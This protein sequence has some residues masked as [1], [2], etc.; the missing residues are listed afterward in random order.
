MLRMIYGAAGAGQHDMMLRE[1]K[2]RTAQKKYSYIL[3]PEQFS[4]SAE[5][6]ILSVLGMSAQ[7]HVEVISFSRLSNM[8]LGEL[9]PLRMKYIDGAGRRI[10]ISRALNET[11]A[12]LGYL[13]RNVHQRGFPAVMEGV[14]SEFKRYGVTPA[15]ALETSK[16][17]KDEEL[18]CKLKDIAAVY[19]KYE[20][21]ISEKYSDAEDNLSL[22][23]PKIEDF[24]LN[25]GMLYIEEF[26]SFTPVEY[27]VLGS[28][29]QKID[30][31]LILCTESLK[32][33]PAAFKSAVSTWDKL[34]NIAQGAGIEISVP[35]K[36][37]SEVKF[38]ERPALAHLK[39]ELFKAR[40]IKYKNQTSEINIYA[41]KNYYAEVDAA[42]R[43]ISQLCHEKGYRFRDFLILARN[44]EKYA[45]IIPLVFESRGINVYLDKRRGIDKKPLMRAIF[46][47]IE[48]AAH[49]FSYDRVMS[50]ARSGFSKVSMRDIDIFENYLL[51][52]APSPRMWHTT[53]DWLF[54]PNK[55]VFDMD[56]INQIRIRL[57]GDTMNMLEPLRRSRTVAQIC[58][59]IKSW[60]KTCNIAG[61]VEAKY[62]LY[63]KRGMP[64]LAEELRQTWNALISILTQL[65][66]TM[67]SC[68]M[69]ASEFLDLFSAAASGAPVGVSPQTLDEVTFAGADRFRD[70]SAKVVIIFDMTEGVFPRAGNIEGIISDAE[71]EE[72]MRA[73]ME[74][75]PGASSRP[76]EEQNLIYRALTAAADSLYLFCPAEDSE[77]KALSPSPIA[78]KI[79]K[80]LFA[81]MDVYVPPYCETV[82]LMMNPEA[83]SES[84]SLEMVE[85]LY[86][87]ELMLSASKIERYNACAFSYFARYGLL[88]RPRDISNLE[89]KDMGSVLHDVLCKYFKQLA[90]DGGDYSAI[91]RNSCFGKIAE[92]TDECARSYDEMLYESS[93]YY[94]YMIM[95]MRRIAQTTAW[96]IVRFY[97]NSD[98]RPLG[99]EMRIGEG[100]DI[101][102]INIECASGNIKIVGAIDRADYAEINGKK[103][104]SILDYKSYKRKIED[105]EV[106][107]GVQIQPLLYSGA[108]TAKD[109]S[110]PA[111]MLYMQMSDP[112]IETNCNE[113]DE[114]DSK[115]HKELRPAGWVMDDPDVISAFDKTFSRT[116]G[117]FVP[118]K[119]GRLPREEMYERILNAEKKIKKSAE[120]ILSGDVSIKP[121]VSKGFSGCTYCDY[122]HIC[123]KKAK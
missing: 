34:C 86:G 115:K 56:E 24:S 12:E 107:G 23:A 54:N 49:G 97:K 80:E 119:G 9:G 89:P 31:C 102:P 71:R 2:T 100:G 112:I 83:I 78:V 73:G 3:V 14:I 18:K 58:A 37:E 74:L 65:E 122:A 108:I 84:I 16:R 72:L 6:E 70:T 15:D 104:I 114:I 106:R 30:I 44:P 11:E 101:P 81:D 46:A 41:P 35:T 29:M 113:Y 64:Y 61:I 27:K 63:E 123:R 48:I 94:K 79:R 1:I 120:G 117:E 87:H 17:V 22:I 91:S 45:G 4:V 67:G 7:R 68:K 116:S 28:L 95:K 69:K 55:R 33:P 77:G 109:G 75:A 110:E 19:S 43:L 98:F 26:K 118:S 76:P 42:S 111:A 66:E 52:A 25:G 5:R 59:A 38:K 60:L 90:N 40:P 47:A 32:N 39:N 105:E 53:D 36:L 10:T 8:V 51:A 13:K 62:K 92:L 82:D 85:K 20:E 88:A 121:F 93:S 57:L 50:Y 103:Y 96:E 99:F 21:L